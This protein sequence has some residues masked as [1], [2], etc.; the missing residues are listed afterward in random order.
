MKLKKTK[1][2]SWLLSSALMLGLVACGSGN[3]NPQ[4]SMTADQEIAGNN[5]LTIEPDTERILRNP[6]NG[7][8]LYG[9]PTLENFWDRYDNIKVPE[10]DHSV[11]IEDYAHTLYMRVSWTML[12]PEEG[13]YGWDTNENFKN[14]V[15]QARKR[16]MRLAFRIVVD[17][18]D[19]PSDFTPDFVR[20][21]GAKGFTS[22]SGKR[23]VWSPFPDDPIFQEKYNK[24]IEAFA[25][26]FND[27]DLV[28]FI[29][30][31]GLGK[32]GEAHGVTYRDDS[33]RESVLR[34]VTD[35]YTKHFTKI[36]LALNYHRLVGVNKSWDVPDP[37]SE[38]LLDE[39]FIKGYILRHDAFGMTPYYEQWEKDYAAKW[40]QKDME[41]NKRPIIMEG[42]WVTKQHRWDLNDPRG[43]KTLG[44]VR[45]GEFD[46]SRDARVN[47]M[48]FRIN[49]TESWFEE[50]YPLVKQFIAEGG[51]RLYPDK[52]SVPNKVSKG[53]E[54]TITHNWNNLGWG[55]CP[56]NIPQWNYRYKV[57]F[58]LLDKQT[59]EVKYIFVDTNSEPSDW[60]KEEATSYTFK[61]TIDAEEGVY[62]WAIALI[63]TSMENRVGLEIAVKADVV[64][65]GWL[66]LMDVEIE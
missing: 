66:P 32:W 41:T 2:T 51:Y 57:A 24:F 38:A 10:L 53:S 49:E 62:E 19:K 22:M 40:L 23:Q 34:W 8:V 33:N 30:G 31:Y 7:W 46:D 65:S 45:Q 3:G 20:K 17:S 27:P 13:V 21:A 1:I 43:Y 61:P 12:N 52:V 39:V 16:N 15:E 54:I 50:S 48:D 63:D 58:A 11:K 4:L 9:S 5:V 55:Y 60:M 35:L 59:K 44:D 36:P 56:N 37:K 64:A 26:K 18:Q 28:D 42:G 25:A 47:M 29:D 14:I 6:L